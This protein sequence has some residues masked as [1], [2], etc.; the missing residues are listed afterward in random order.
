MS[1][2]SFTARRRLSG[3]APIA[4]QPFT[5]SGMACDEAQPAERAASTFIATITCPRCGEP[6][7]RAP[8][9]EVVERELGGQRGEKRSR[10]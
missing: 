2:Q 5:C 3:R 1:T 7:F 8:F 6:M 10:A 4:E 9:A